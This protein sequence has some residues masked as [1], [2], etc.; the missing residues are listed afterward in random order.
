MAEKIK[1]SEIPVGSSI[2]IEEEDGY[3]SYSLVQHNYNSGV[4]LLL[5]DMVVDQVQWSA[6]S[7]VTMYEGNTLDNWQTYTWYPSQPSSTQ[8]LLTDVSYPVVSSVSNKSQGA[9]VRK[10][11]IPSISEL[12]YQYDSYHGSLFTSRTINIGTT[13]WTRQL[14]NGSSAFYVNSSGSFGAN[15]VTNTY[16]VRPC[17]GISETKL[18]AQKDDSTGIY[19]LSIGLTPPSA[20]YF[21]DNEIDFDNVQPNLNFLLTWPEAESGTVASYVVFADYLDGTS[22]LVYAGSSPYTTV[23][24][25]YKGYM[26]TVFSLHTMFEEDPGIIYPTTMTRYI[27]T[28]KSRINV[29]APITEGGDPVWRLAVPKHFDGYSW[30]EDPNGMHYFGEDSTVR[31]YGEDI[32]LDSAYYYVDQ[33]VGGTAEYGFESTDDVWYKSTNHSDNT[34]SLCKVY[35]HAVNGTHLTVDCVNNS[36]QSP[37]GCYDY[38]LLSNLNATED[39]STN[40]TVNIMKSFVDDSSVDVVRVDYGTLSA[41][42][43]YFY[44]KYYKDYSTSYGEDTFKFK[45]IQS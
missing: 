21:Y 32:P 15:S 26:K 43:Y 25:P 17:I 8:R 36:E 38:G 22:E 5:R 9:I 13:Y 39:F 33:D 16:G 28:I 30:I 44:A 2:A 1:V 27:S 40:N 29:Y 35:V 4:A 42:D 19:W 20:L 18:T 12:S 41:G 3:S 14:Q 23:S 45:V 11:C 37:T 34:Y 10:A 6:S 31:L 7:S 24:S